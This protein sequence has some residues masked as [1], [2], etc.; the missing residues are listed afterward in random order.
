MS[1]GLAAGLPQLIMPMTH[2]QPDNADRAIRL[3]IGDAILPKRFR[4][5]A[6]A[7]SLRGLLESADVLANCRAVAARLSPR[8]GVEAACDLVEQ[9]GTTEQ[10]SPMALPQ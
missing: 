2:D 10:E 9:L 4:P 3:G 1:Q 5:V 6:V 7:A 8:V